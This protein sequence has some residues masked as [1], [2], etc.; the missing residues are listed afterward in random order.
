MVNVEGIIYVVDMFCIIWFKINNVG[1]FVIIINVELIIF[2]NKLIFV[3][4]MCLILFVRL[5]V[6][7]IN[8]FE[9]SV[10]RFIVILIVFMF[11]L[12]FCC[13]FGIIFISDCVNN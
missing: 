9:N 1:K 7:I 10:V 8:M 12:K 11:V 3:I 2:N 6:L 4:F 13:K 5:F